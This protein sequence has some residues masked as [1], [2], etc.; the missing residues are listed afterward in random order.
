M[1]TATRAFGSQGPERDLYFPIRKFYMYV[2]VYIFILDLYLLLI[3]VFFVF[4]ETH[5][6]IH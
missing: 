3:P 5:K 2:C 6:K 4:N 1:V